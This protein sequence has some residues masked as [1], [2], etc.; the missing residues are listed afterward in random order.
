MMAAANCPVCDGTR[1][2]RT[3]EVLAGRPSTLL[4]RSEPECMERLLRDLTEPPDNPGYINR[5]RKG[6]D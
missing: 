4:Y 6:E 5:I 1:S 2:L 3:L